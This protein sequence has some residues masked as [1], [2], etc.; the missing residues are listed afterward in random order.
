MLDMEEPLEKYLVVL[1]EV[2][3]QNGIESDNGVEQVHL[4]E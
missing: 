1:V 2:Q 3:L 4:R